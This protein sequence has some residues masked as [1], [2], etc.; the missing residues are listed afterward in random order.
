MPDSPKRPPVAADQSASLKVRVYS[1]TPFGAPDTKPRPK[2]T[3]R[4]G[5]TPVAKPIPERET[6]NW[7]GLPNRHSKKPLSE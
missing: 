6:L 2:A 7:D 1:R 4:P 3:P 5:R